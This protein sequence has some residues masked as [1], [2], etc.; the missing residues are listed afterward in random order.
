MSV[1]NT[2]LDILKKNI[3][4][5][6]EVSKNVNLISESICSACTLKNPIGTKNC[7]A[8]GTLLPEKLK[9][10]Y[11]KKCSQCTLENPI[12][13]SKCSA[14]D[15]TKFKI[16]NYD[17][18][19]ERIKCII[20]YFM[21]LPIT[22]NPIQIIPSFTG[23]KKS[24]VIIMRHGIRADNCQIIKKVTK[25]NKWGKMTEQ[26]ERINKISWPD[27]ES[28]PYDPPLLDYDLPL[29]RAKEFANEY[30]ITKIVSSPF[31][32]CL[33]TAAIIARHL[34]ITEIEINEKFGEERDAFSRY[35]IP[36]YTITED[37]IREALGD[38]QLT[39]KAGQSITK[40][41]ENYNSNKDQFLKGINEYKGQTNLLIVSH[42]D[43]FEIITNYYIN[44]DGLSIR[45]YPR[46]EILDG[47]HFIK[48]KD[49]NDEWPP[50]ITASPVECAYT[51]FNIDT[52]TI[53]KSRGITYVL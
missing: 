25:L 21:K 5:L 50:I 41:A 46:Q 24:S 37:I 39:K 23:T 52:R 26:D 48:D 13:N 18:E 38:I 47:K 36:I 27:M 10:T 51:E 45:K 28:R 53:I 12:I 9:I 49:G 34:G 14:C 4:E 22:F 1:I 2:E 11:S 30:N 7:E 33:Q 8:C 44:K 15:G 29:I 20:N 3:F 43:I 16:T 17:L 19:Y 6:V 35:K 42:G 40:I 32:R 31:R